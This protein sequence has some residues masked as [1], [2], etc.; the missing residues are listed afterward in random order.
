[1]TRLALA[2]AQLLLAAPAPAAP[3]ENWPQWRGPDGDGVSHETGFPAEW[4]PGKN[5]VWTFPLPAK[6]S[7]TP[8]VWGDHIFL[9]SMDKGG[10][11][12]LLCIGTDGKERWQRKL[13]SSAVR[14]RTPG[15]EGDGASAS[16]STD[17]K[18]VYV[19]AGSGDLAC[20]DFAGNEVWRVDTRERYGPFKI[21]FG[22][23]VTPA[24][25]GDR[26]YLSFLHANG[27]WVAALDKATGRE[28]WKVERPSDGRQECEQSYASPVIWHKGADAY[29]LVHGNDYTTAHRLAD[30]KE[31]WRLGDLNPKSRYNNTLRF[32]ASP[33]ATPDLIVSPTAK[34]G[35]VVGVRPDASGEIRAGGKGEQWRRPRD[36]P[37]VS[38]PLVYD[39]VVYLCDENGYATAMDGV[40]G[41][42]LYRERIHSALYRASPVYADGKVYMVARDGTVTVLRAGRTFDKLAEN[43]LPDQ[44]AASPS[45]SR[46]RIYLRGYQALYAIGTE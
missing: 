23:H 45:I 20:F 1:M 21:M 5:V 42:E 3:A 35:P 17:G 36:T 27:Q 38:S 32:V 13:N 28:V 25:Y 26:L 41:R 44:I 16:P 29:L 10:D 15:G 33:V 43:R 12:L 39:G 8:A 6:G 4:G 24:L 19:F 30:G 14:I 46:G 40:S 11:V 34:H 2:L 7:S 37:D 22:L 9:T 18:H 31:L